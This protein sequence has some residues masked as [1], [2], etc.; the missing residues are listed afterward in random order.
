M[1]RLGW[2]C[3]ALALVLPAQAAEN[4]AQFYQYMD[5]R[6]KTRQREIKEIL[7][8]GFGSD[9]IAR[10]AGIDDEELVTWA[11]VKFKACFSGSELSYT[12]D[13]DALMPVL[14]NNLDKTTTLQKGGIEITLQTALQP[15]SNLV[16]YTMQLNL[17]S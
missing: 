13:G 16:A 4:T 7:V 8:I 6:I 11:V 2:F 10:D 5:Q 12:G 15:Q 17:F 9:K 3:L 1:K 14:A